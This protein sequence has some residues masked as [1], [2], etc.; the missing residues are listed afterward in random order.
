MPDQAQP[1][2]NHIEQYRQASSPPRPYVIT[3]TSGKGGV[4]KSTVALN[5]GLALANRGLRV[6]LLDADANLASLDLLSGISPRYRVSDVLRGKC[7]IEDALVTVHPGVHLLPGSSGEIDF[8]LVGDGRRHQLLLDLNELE[9]RHDVILIDTAAGLT[10]EVVDYAVHA[11]ETLVVTG[12]EPTALMDAYAMVKVLTRTRASLSVSFLVNAVRVPR[13]GEEAAMKLQQVITHF[14]KREC[15]CLGAI[16]FD[17]AVQKSIMR[18]EPLLRL[19][20]RSAASLCL[21]A[22]GQELLNAHIRS[23][24]RRAATA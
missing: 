24:M 11:D 3:I 8:P 17:G 9:E 4:G 6:L 12:V 18:Q 1:L 19:F 5:V 15:P 14:L 22:V 16:P 7:D 2:R 21:D 23:S 13:E 10:R 20:P